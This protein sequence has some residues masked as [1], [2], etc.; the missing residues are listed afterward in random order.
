MGV[1]WTLNILYLA[2]MC[3]HVTPSLHHLR[4]KLEGDFKKVNIDQAMDDVKN[5]VRDAESDIPHDLQAALKDIEGVVILPI[6]DKGVSVDKSGCRCQ[7]YDCGCCAD[8]KIPDVMDNTLCA[9]ITYLPADIGISVSISI[10]GQVVF[11]STISARNPPPLCL[12]VPYLKHM[13]SVCLRFYNLDISKSFSGCMKFVIEVLHE[14]V[15]DADLGCFKIPL[16]E[17]WQ[18]VVENKLVLGWID[19]KTRNGNLTKSNGN[20]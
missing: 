8:V 17:K 13:L 20:V 4:I 19:E 10:D 12:K 7:N 14:H 15:V 2:A 5:V 1:H 3:H 6:V 18:S 9:N 16:E 11:K